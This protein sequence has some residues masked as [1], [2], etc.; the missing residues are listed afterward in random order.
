MHHGGAFD[1]FHHTDYHGKALS[2][3]CELKFWSYFEILGSLKELGYVQV[4]SMWHYDP[5][6][7]NELVLEEKDNSTKRIKN[8]AKMNG[9]FHIYVVHPLS[10][11]DLI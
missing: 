10:Q 4:E 11:L 9:K 6:D 3:F 1:K 5:K 8:I 7:V 2:W